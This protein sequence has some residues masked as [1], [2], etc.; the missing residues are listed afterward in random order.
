MTSTTLIT[1]ITP[2]VWVGCLACYNDGCLTGQWIDAVDALD[3]TPEDLHEDETSHEELWCFD[4]ENFPPEVGEMDRLTAARWGDLYEEIGEDYW[5]AFLAWVANDGYSTDSF[6]L[7]EASEFKDSYRG[8]FSSFSDYIQQELE[9]TCFFDGWPD[10]AIR[11]FNW[12]AYE[13]NAKY[14]FSVLDAPSGVYVFA[15]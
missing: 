3:I 12:D 4:I 10:A 1:T 9:D 6:G 11:Y 15:H 8:R 2:R 5:E 7:P 13:R 14:D